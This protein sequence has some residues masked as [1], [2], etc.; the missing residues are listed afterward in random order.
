[1]KKESKSKKR[2]YKY[3]VLLGFIL[4]ATFII[5]SSKAIKYTS[6]DEFCMSCHVH[7][8]A[9]DA[10]RLSTHYDN[11]S[12]IIVHCVQCHLPPPGTFNYLKAKAVTGARDVYAMVFKDTDK[13]NWEAKRQLSAAVKHTFQESCQSCHQNL[14]PR[15]LSEEGMHAHLYYS[16]NQEQLNCLNCHLHVGHYS[17]LEHKPMDI[18]LGAIVAPIAAVVFEDAFNI[19]TFERFT[20]TIPGTSVKFDMVPIPGGVFEIGSPPREPGRSSNEGPVRQVELSPFFMAEVE[21]TWEMYMTF[22]RETASE[23]RTDQG[24]FM[25]DLSRITEVDAISGPTPP[26][27]NPDQGWGWGQR[28]A[29]TMTYYGAETF[30]RWLSLKTGK[31]YR[32]PTEAEWEYAARGGTTTPYFFEGNP[33]KFTTTRIWNRVFGAD[34]T[35]INR[36]IIYEANSLMRTQPPD[37]VRANPF[38]LRNMLGN[39]WEF[40]SDYYADDAYAIYPEGQ[41]IRNPQGPATGKERVIRGGSYKSD[42]FDVRSATRRPT[43][44]DAWLI[45]DPQIP[46]SIWWYSDQ[47]EVGFRVVLD[48]PGE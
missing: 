23:G 35:N 48:W 19:E 43:Q 17:E 24:A 42:A 21:I 30:C 1:M 29:I 34:T 41:V 16:N 36:Y 28:P 6:T 37:S 18:G 10:W 31:N 38:G 2:R 5:L 8:H 47:N 11:Q 13:I 44:H 33:R 15:Q 39:V 20:E 14:F 7:P 3:L 12:G 9:E 40:T 4:G 45:T 22:F 46:K 26:W 25:A 32:L 27:G